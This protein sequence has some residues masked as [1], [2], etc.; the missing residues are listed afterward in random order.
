[1]AEKR[2]RAE[3]LLSYRHTL[4]RHQLLL[5]HQ[6]R[7]EVRR[8]KTYVPFCTELVADNLLDLG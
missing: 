7:T 8:Y 1:M 3:A 6:W 4:V 2:A 5:R